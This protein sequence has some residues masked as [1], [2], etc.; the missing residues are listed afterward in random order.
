MIPVDQGLGPFYLNITTIM[1]H[2]I[3]KDIVKHAQTG[4]LY[5]LSL[6]QLRHITIFTHYFLLEEG[7]GVVVDFQMFRTLLQPWLIQLSFVHQPT[8][9]MNKSDSKLLAAAGLVRTYICGNKYY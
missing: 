1:W 9:K 5:F 8:M 4:L 3:I 7:F 6:P 2:Y